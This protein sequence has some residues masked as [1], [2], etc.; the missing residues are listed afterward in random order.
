MNDAAV[1]PTG[2]A[3]AT[4]AVTAADGVSQRASEWSSAGQDEDT[5]VFVLLPG[6]G[7]AAGYYE[8][9]AR[10]LAQ[11]RPLTVVLADLRGQGTSTANPRRDDFGYR[12]MLDL[13]FPALFV[14]LAARYGSRPLIVA[15]HS[16]GGQLATIYAGCMP[17][18]VAGL[19][20]L[21]AG[22]THVALWKGPRRIAVSAYTSLVRAMGAAWP[23]YP[24]RLIAFGGDHPKRLIRDWGHVG[25]TGR[26]EPEGARFD[27]EAA[28]RRATMPVLSV[29]IRGDPLVPPAARKALVDRLPL[30]RSRNVEIPRP[31]GS[32]A[33]RSHFAWA[34]RPDHMVA[35]VDDWLRD[36]FA[37]AASEERIARGRG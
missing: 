32:S 35:A 23:W 17:A 34:R 6:L 15:G 36:L 18:N 28:C 3:H 20:I 29:G 22:S 13:D 30:A 8:P 37:D 7:V 11:R 4:F 10:M 9:F 26:Y 14:A 16:L 25:A 5:S 27:Y 24:G 2:I 19:A 21:A 33:W 31:A 1:S 12:E